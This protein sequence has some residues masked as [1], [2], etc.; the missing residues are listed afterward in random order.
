MTKT[1]YNLPSWTS[2]LSTILFLSEVLLVYSPDWNPLKPLKSSLTL[3]SNEMP[4]WIPSFSTRLFHAIPTTSVPVL[5]NAWLADPQ[6]A[7]FCKPSL[8]C[9][10]I[11]SLPTWSR[12]V[13]VTP[14]LVS[15]NLRFLS[16][17]PSPYL[18]PSSCSASA[19]PLHSSHV[20][21][22]SIPWTHQAYSCLEFF[23]L[24]FPSFPLLST[25][26]Q[27]PSKDLIL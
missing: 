13:W 5:I 21:L 1:F 17:L 15:S 25:L 10:S 27:D 8:P 16:W 18:I 12:V 20:G 2:L 23:A 24:W 11:M 4:R 6:M 7:L 14:F 22:L 3:M 26:F 19:S 9:H